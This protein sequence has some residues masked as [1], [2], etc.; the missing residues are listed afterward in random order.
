MYKSHLC[1]LISL[2]A[3]D[4]ILG[5]SGPKKVLDVLG[6]FKESIPVKVR[7]QKKGAGG[8]CLGGGG[9]GWLLS[10]LTTQCFL[11]EVYI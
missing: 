8:V 4:K 10:Q 11:H 6:N 2:R 1:D 9:G 5:V 3:L 7:F